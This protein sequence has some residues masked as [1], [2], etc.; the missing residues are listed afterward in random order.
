MKKVKSIQELKNLNEGESIFDIKLGV[1]VT[2]EKVEFDYVVLDIS[3]GVSTQSN[4][5]EN[6]LSTFKMDGRYS[7]KHDEIER[8]YL[9]S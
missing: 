2:V 4:Y 1:G 7:V 6:W 3:H 5:R 8:L 9:K